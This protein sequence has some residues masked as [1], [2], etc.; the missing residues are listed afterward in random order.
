[1]TFRIVAPLLLATCLSAAALVQA[2]GLQQPAALI[3][4]NYCG[5]GNNAPWPPVDALDAACAR[6][7]A[8]TPIGGLPSRACNLRLQWETDR[9]SRDLRQPDDIRALA[10]FIAAGAALL[11]FDPNAPIAVRIPAS[12][13]YG[14]P[15]APSHQPVYRAY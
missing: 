3:H 2:S 14:A 8:C 13:R 6:H 11:P 12:V 1:M 15:P 10:G 9:I 5:L 7:D 4:G